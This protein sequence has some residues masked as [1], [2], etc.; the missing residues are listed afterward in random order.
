MAVLV[1]E[2]VVIDEISV[3][4]ETLFIDS[5]VLLG[6]P[7]LVGVPLTHRGWLILSAWTRCGGICASGFPWHTSVSAKN[8]ARSRASGVSLRHWTLRDRTVTWLSVS[9]YVW[10][11]RFLCNG[12]PLTCTFNQFSFPSTGSWPPWPNVHEIWT[13]FHSADEFKPRKGDGW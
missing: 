9:N 11:S 5:V 3:A 1:R 10:S 13:Q 12:S 7:E 6:D 4:L 8:A 2:L